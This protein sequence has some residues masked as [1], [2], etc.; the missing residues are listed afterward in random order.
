MLF[1]APL[2]NPW[3]NSDNPV[4]IATATVIDLLLGLILARPGNQQHQQLPPFIAQVEFIDGWC[5]VVRK[6]K[7]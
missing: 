4:Y 3:P 7:H 6:P 5:R 2:L 1:S